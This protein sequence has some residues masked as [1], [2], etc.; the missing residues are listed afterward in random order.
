MPSYQQQLQQYF[1]AYEK[2]QGFR[3][4]SLQDVAGWMI[5]KGYWEIRESDQIKR[6][7]SDLA[8]ALRNEYRTDPLG[9]RYRVN[10]AVR[11]SQGTFWAD[12]DKAPR[13]HMEK[14]F[15]Q[16][17]QQIVGDCVQ[18]T[19]D[20]YVYNDKNQKE[21]PINLVLDFTHDVEEVL[22]TDMDTAA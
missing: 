9:R 3:P 17:R 18:L 10:H 14:A 11:G 1:H 19:T 21:E 6:C 4:S 13:R 5:Q 12:L 8:D 20:V 16:R 2:E 7:A 15:A 22:L